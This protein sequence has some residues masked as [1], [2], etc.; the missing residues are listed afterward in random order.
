MIGGDGSPQTNNQMI[1]I[2]DH[3]ARLVQDN[4]PNAAALSDQLQQQQMQINQEQLLQQ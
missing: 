4:S 1:N 3:D 2:S